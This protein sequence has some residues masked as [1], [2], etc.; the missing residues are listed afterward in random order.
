MKKFFL[1][2]LF[3]FLTLNFS[4]FIQYD[5]SSY[6]FT[7]NNLI[8]YMKEI[9]LPYPYIILAQCKLE[10]GN[11]KSKIFRKNNNL[12]GMKEAKVRINLAKGTRYNHAYYN[13]WTES[14]IDYALWYSTYASDC[15]NEEDF[16]NLL[17]RVY[18]KSPKY[19]SNLQY[20]IKNENLKSKFYEQ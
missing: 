12:T 6:K 20:I 8:S 1:L 2:I 9:N 15:K 3:L 14:I 4:N 19:V 5:V 7:E 13:H 11:Y 16:Y 10:T 18:A 17:Q